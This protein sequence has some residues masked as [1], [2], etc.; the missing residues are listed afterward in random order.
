[1]NVSA[2][3]TSDHHHR[4]SGLSWVLDEL[5]CLRDVGKR[6]AFG[7]IESLPAGFECSIDV[8]SGFTLRLG[9]NIVTADKEQ[10]RVDK[11]KLPDRDLRH[12]SVGGVSGDGTA[13]RQDLDV[14]LDV[15]GEGHFYDV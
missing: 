11:G 8:A 12:R 4:S 10:S 14:G 1:M 13:L 2:S 6:E 9:R 3:A 5:V 15:G 7:D